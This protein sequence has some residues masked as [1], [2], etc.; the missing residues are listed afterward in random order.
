MARAKGTNRF[1]DRQIIDALEKAS[2]IQIVAVRL[3]E[4]TYKRRCTRSQINARIQRS[5]KLRAALDDI[6]EKDLDI[7]EGKLKQASSAGESWAV[8]F[9]LKTKGK[10][11]GYSE[12]WEITGPDGG[13]VQQITRVVTPKDVREMS[14]D[15]LSDFIRGECGSGPGTD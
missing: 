6:I 3:L 12:K 7:A 15:E 2:G 1:T 13:P 5:P 10:R 11:R 14:D 4:D 9:T 8:M